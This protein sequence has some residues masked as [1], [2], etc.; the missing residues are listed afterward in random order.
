MG[1]KLNRSL[2][3]ILKDRR[4]SNRRARGAGRRANGTKAAVLAAPV[5]GVKKT[6]KTTKPTDK[7]ALATGSSGSG[8]SKIIVSNL[9]SRSCRPPI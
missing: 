6:T 8:D 3:E 1:D 7:P 5:G 9:V 2:D 4:Q